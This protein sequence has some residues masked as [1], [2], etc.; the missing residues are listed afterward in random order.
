VENGWLGN[1]VFH[2]V[3]KFIRLRSDCEALGIGKNGERAKALKSG[4]ELNG[5]VIKVR[6]NL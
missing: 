2:A 6:K 3:P 1:L 5:G 4:T